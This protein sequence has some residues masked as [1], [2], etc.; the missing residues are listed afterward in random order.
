MKLLLDNCIDRNFAALIK[1]HEVVHA[2]D[3]GWRDLE[4]GKLLAAAAEAG[5]AAMITV[6][7]N[8][9]Y[10]QN[11]NKVPIAIVELDAIRNRIDELSK[12][13]PHISKALDLTA[14]FVFVSI[15]DDGEIEC[16]AE[17]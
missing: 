9:R 11:L 8:I 6:D 14:K 1:D 10:Q 7:K 16:L 3:V 4:N 12:F 13:I 17:R 2:R 5:F 15:K